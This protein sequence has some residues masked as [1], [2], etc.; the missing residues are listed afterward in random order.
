MTRACLSPCMSMTARSML[1][2]SCNHHLLV[3]VAPT[4]PTLYE[5]GFFYMFEYVQ[6]GCVVCIRIWP[7]PLVF[8]FVSSSCPKFFFNNSFCLVARSTKVKNVGGF[9]VFL[10]ISWNVVDKSFIFKSHF[11]P[12]SREEETNINNCFTNT[13]IILV[14]QFRI[15]LKSVQHPTFQNIENVTPQC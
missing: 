3:L 7:G 14:K 15:F 10:S 5:D 13:P 12:V 1:L 8:H 9:R 2:S 6:D 4:L 11:G